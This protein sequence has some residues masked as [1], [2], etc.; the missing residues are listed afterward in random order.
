MIRDFIKI[1]KNYYQLICDNKS[2]LIPYYI[3]YFSNV[4]IGLL[5]PIYVAKITDSLTNSLFKTAVISTIIFFVLK[6]G[7]NLVSYFNMFTYQRFY[8]YNY[9]TIYKKIVNKIYNFDSLYKKNIPT[10]KMFNS[11]INDVVNIGEMA[12]NVLTIILNSLTCIIIVFYFLRIN[13][14]LSL[15]I[16]II[17]IIYIYRCNYLNNNITK[18]SEK[19]WLENDRL[20]GLINQTLLGL[21]DIQTLGFS[22]SID[23]KYN[24]IYSSWRKVYNQKKKYEREIRSLLKCFIALAKTVLYFFCIYLIIKKELTIGM[25]LIIISYFD[26]LFSASENI[27]S[28]T[29]SIK[30]QNISVNRIKDIL[31]YNSV[32]K[33]ELNNIN[34]ISGQIEFKNVFFSYN[35]DKFLEKINFTISPNKITAI[36]GSNGAGK[37]TIINLILRLYSPL[38]GKI[39]LDNIDISSINKRL[40]LR[41]ISVLNQEAY[42]FN[43]SI[44]ENF[45]LIN[46]NIKKQEEICNFIGIDDFIKKLPKGYDTIIDENSD[47]VSGG[48]QKLLSLARML[49]KESKILIFDE[50]TSSLDS[51]MINKIINIL[52]KLK[53]NHTVII[54]THKKEIIDIS[55]EKIIVEK[56]HVKF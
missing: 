53:K 38:K 21:K 23:N 46:K 32:E 24:N 22:K 8:Q 18:Y 30:D 48:Q 45:N 50:V 6:I 44:R 4:I 9:I 16:I 37:T 31:D 10:G 7:N 41:E 14:I 36:I 2:K 27:M 47:N 42:L 17:D 35:N 11:L 34:N 49:L 26:S 40:Y 43:L 33:K 55:D 29:V 54:I 5:I 12:D 25:M 20:I 3:G 1:T 56:G 19:Q 51:G 28:A 39:F 52:E 13:V 15:L